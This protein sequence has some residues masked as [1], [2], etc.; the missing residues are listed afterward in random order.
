[1][2]SIEGA[3][4]LKLDESY[5]I[6]NSEEQNA[7]I[8]SFERNEENQIEEN[9]INKSHSAD[10]FPSGVSIESTT[11][12]ENNLENDINENVIT[13]NNFDQRK[14]KEDSLLNFSMRKIMISIN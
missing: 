13:D 5:E 4:A 11:Y 6:K 10:E 8:D 9:S 3:N 14:Y 7:L 12:I 2:G 1:M